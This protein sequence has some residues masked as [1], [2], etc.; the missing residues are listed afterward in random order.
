[1]LFATGCDTVNVYCTFAQTCNR[2]RVVFGVDNYRFNICKLN[3]LTQFCMAVLHVWCMSNVPYHTRLISSVSY[4]YIWYASIFLDFELYARYGH[5]VAIDRLV[6]SLSYLRTELCS[7]DMSEACFWKNIFCASPFKT[8][9]A[10]CWN[11]F[12]T[13]SILPLLCSIIF[14]F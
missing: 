1:V 12:N 7:T 4:T 11:S 13:T 3:E 6:P 5:V 10:R 8:L 9:Q 2:V 14:S